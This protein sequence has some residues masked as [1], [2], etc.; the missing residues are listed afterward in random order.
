VDRKCT[1][2]LPGVLTFGHIAP[3]DGKSFLYA[4]PGS[5]DV[6]IYRQNW[7]NGKSIGP[8]SGCAQA[9]IRLSLDNQRQRLRLL[10]R[11]GGRSELY[12]LGNK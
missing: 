9:A 10:A 4:V 3:P 12:Y 7:Q 5:R 11:P 1:P 6:S 2:L 8:A